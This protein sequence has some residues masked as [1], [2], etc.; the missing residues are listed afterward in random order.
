M[1]TK[2]F[3]HVLVT[4]LV[5]A[6]KS[7]FCNSLKERFV[8][9]T[10]CQ[11]DLMQDSMAKRHGRGKAAYDLAGKRLKTKGNSKEGNKSL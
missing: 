6:K 8:Q 3:Y 4:F 11:L 2:T 10:F 9:F 7:E 1:E 5:A